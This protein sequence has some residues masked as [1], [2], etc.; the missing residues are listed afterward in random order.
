MLFLEQRAL[1]YKNAT[2]LCAAAMSAG[3]QGSP[4]KLLYVPGGKA[5]QEKAA[6]QRGFCKAVL[7]C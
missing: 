1:Q 4:V 6:L 5:G 7:C 2:D 3:A